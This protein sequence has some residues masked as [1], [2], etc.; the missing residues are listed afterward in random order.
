MAGD[1]N[2]G[3][4]PNGDSRPRQDSTTMPGQY[5]RPLPFGQNPPTGTGAPGSAG[6]GSTATDPTMAGSATPTSVFGAPADNLH[7]GSPGTQGATPHQTTGASYTDPFAYLSGGNAGQM[8]GGS[9][10]TEAQGDKAGHP[11]PFNTPYPTDT[12]VGH[13]KTLIGGR[14]GK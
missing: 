7:T 10:D 6:Q 9:T 3:S 14:G 2:T 1:R 13:G 12:G 5:P 8:T 4:K 11:G